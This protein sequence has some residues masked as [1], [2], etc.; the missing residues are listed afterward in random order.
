VRKV[1][2]LTLVASVNNEVEFQGKVMRVLDIAY[3]DDDGV[4]STQKNGRLQYRLTDGEVNRWVPAEL[5]TIPDLT[6]EMEPGTYRDSITEDVGQPIM[7]S[8]YAEYLKMKAQEETSMEIEEEGRSPHLEELGYSMV[9][10][11]D[12]LEARPDND[13][14]PAIMSILLAI[15][16]DKEGSYGSSWKGKGEYRGIMANIDRKYDRLDKM[17]DDEIESGRTLRL[18]EEGLRTGRLTEEQVGESKIDAIADLTNYGLLYM[19]YVREN[20]PNVFKV[21]VDRNVP[22]YLADKIPFI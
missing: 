6:V 2:S 13:N 11:L 5:V 9:G 4:F 8:S 1:G 20:F 14:I 22:K 19:T 15:Q 3:M 18:M 21:W 17:T 16:Y 7:D 12:G 10:W